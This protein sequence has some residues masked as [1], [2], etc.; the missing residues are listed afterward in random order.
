MPASST[1]PSTCVTPSCP[2]SSS[3][4]LPPRCNTPAA[5]RSF[6]TSNLVQL[7]YSAIRIRNPKFAFRNSPEVPM[8]ISVAKVLTKVFGSRNDRLLKRYRAIVEKISEL[9]P[10]VAAMT[11]EQLRARTQE[12]REGLTAKK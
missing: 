12:L 2:P 10:K 5:V 9:E 4:C 11:D 7:C 3:D 1:A 6:R 8:A